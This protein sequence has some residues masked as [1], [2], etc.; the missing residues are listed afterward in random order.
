MMRRSGRSRA[1]TRNS[2][3]KKS[4]WRSRSCTL[5]GTRAKRSRHP[6]ARVALRRDGI[7]PPN[8]LSSGC[9]AMPHASTLGGGAPRPR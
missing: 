4:V 1:A 8:A 9:G 2:E 6:G 3:S 5:M 7:R